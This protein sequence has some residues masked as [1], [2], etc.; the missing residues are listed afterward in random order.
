[1]LLVH[2][3]GSGPWIFDEWAD[4]FPTSIL[5]AVDLQHHVPVQ[6]ASMRS[7]ANEIGR[8]ARPLPRPIAIV[9][10]SMGGLVAM[11]Q[12]PTLGAMCL[13]LLEPSPP[14]EIQGSHASTSIVD[15]GAFD[16]EVV[17]GPFPPGIRSRPESSLA[18]AERT[19]GISVPTV[20]CPSVVV[21]GSEFPVERGS[22][23]AAFY[24]SDELRFPRFDHWG[25]VREHAV[26]ASIAEHLG[27][28]LTKSRSRP[29]GS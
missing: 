29:S 4:T 21:S 5:H 15:P 12:A 28:S 13:V 3:A 23:V 10:W 16:P 20:P 19:A 18:R 14:A 9:A 11:M 24:R 17:Y 8:A 1:V 2:G 26:R 7:Y 6:R 22:R 27:F 25:L